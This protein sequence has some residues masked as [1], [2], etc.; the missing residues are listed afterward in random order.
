[1]YDFKITT[2]TFIATK[3]ITI[4]VNILFSLAVLMVSLQAVKLC[5]VYHSLNPPSLYKGGRGLTSSN[6]AI[7]VGMKYFF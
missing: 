3:N 7:R 6:L 2:E 4:I 1:M 5:T